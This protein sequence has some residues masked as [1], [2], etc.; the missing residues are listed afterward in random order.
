MYGFLFSKLTEAA[1]IRECVGGTL[2][3]ELPQL[4]LSPYFCLPPF[5]MR[6]DNSARPPPPHLPPPSLPMMVQP[7][8]PAWAPILLTFAITGLPMAGKL[9]AQYVLAPMPL[10]PAVDRTCP[11]VLQ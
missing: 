6:P 7:D 9:A 5:A 4:G 3:S 10:L 11:S 1:C 2:V 8:N